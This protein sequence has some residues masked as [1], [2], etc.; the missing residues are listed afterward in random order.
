M[1][2]G[3]GVTPEAQGGSPQRERI[4]RAMVEVVGGRGLRNSELGDLLAAAGVTE[5]EFRRHFTDMEDCFVQVWQELTAEHAELMA[6][7]Y[8][9]TPDWRRR[10]RAMAQL[11]LEF[12]QAD[13]NRARFLVL[14][15]LNAGE[16]AQALRDVAI[17]GQAALIDEGRQLLDHPDSI[18]P[19]VA[20]HVAGAINEM[21]IRNTENGELFNGDT[22]VRELMYL[23]VRPYLGHEAALEE[24]RTP[25]WGD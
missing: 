24:L 25:V 12:L 19:A 6:A 18:S 3:Y 11:T 5:E 16:T 7:A 15:V 17:A 21:L 20:A 22:A 4:A 14:E 10:M 13:R 1:P 2:V 8:G 23:A 9:R